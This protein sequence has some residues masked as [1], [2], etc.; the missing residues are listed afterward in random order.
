MIT[1]ILIGFVTL[2]SIGLLLFVVDLFRIY[3]MGRT[4]GIFQ[5]LL[6]SAPSP[7]R[8]VDGPEPFGLEAAEQAYLDGF[9]E[10]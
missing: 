4:H 1:A 10:G 8:E 6:R 9:F 7:A 2:T 5:F 3:R